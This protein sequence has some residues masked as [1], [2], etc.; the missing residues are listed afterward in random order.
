V[1]PC[2]ELRRGINLGLSG[3]DNEFFLTA[4]ITKSEYEYI[5]KSILNALTAMNPK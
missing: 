5:L 2:K 1:R 4:K 3:A